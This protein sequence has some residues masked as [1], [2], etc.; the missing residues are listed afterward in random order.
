[1]EMCL[2]VRELLNKGEEILTAYKKQDASIDARLLLL[3]L[4]EWE[5]SAFLLNQNKKIPQHI[6]ESYF[7]LIAK[8]SRG[9]PLQ[10]ITKEQ[11]FMGLSFYVDD[12]VLIP[13]QDTE[14]LVEVLIEKNKEHLFQKA[15]E[16]GVGSGCISISLAK[17]LPSLHIIGLDICKDALEIAAKNAK[18]NEVEKQITLMQSDVFEQYEGEEGSLDLIVSNPPYI[19]ET[20]FTD[21]MEEVKSFEPT[22]ALTDYQDGLSFYRKITEQ[23]F[24]YLREGGILAYEIGYKQAKAVSDLLRQRGFKHI[25]VIQDLTKKDR[26]VIAQK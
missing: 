20:E 17:S 14:T 10:Y 2:T 19:S 3:H 24:G 7:Y 8:R 23:A 22:K 26:V 4:L 12:R 18:S 15:L 9:I 13:R 25:E 21:L 11:E 16:I 6:Q 1:M 5:M